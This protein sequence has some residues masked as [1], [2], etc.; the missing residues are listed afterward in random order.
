M[1]HASQCSPV[2]IDYF[3][4][5]FRMAFRW[6]LCWAGLSFLALSESV[7]VPTSDKL[8]YVTIHYEG[9]AADD[10]YILGVRVLLRSLHPLKHP[11][12]I[13]ISKS[14]SQSSRDVFQ[15]EGATLVEVCSDVYLGPLTR[16][17]LD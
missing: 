16:I 7:D 8:A 3:V 15:R 1:D 12:I 9:T 17:P 14:V 6:L 11:F 4:I 10:E 5:Q 2:C 13:L